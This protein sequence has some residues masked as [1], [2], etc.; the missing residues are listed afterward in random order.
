MN[1][2]ANSNETARPAMSL[3][4]ER[5]CN[6]VFTLDSF[7]AAWGA[8]GLY[9]G[10]SYTTTW[11]DVIHAAGLGCGWCRIIQENGEK[12]RCEVLCNVTMSFSEKNSSGCTPKGVA[13]MRLIINKLHIC[14][15]FIYTEAGKSFDYCN[16]VH[17]ANDRY[18]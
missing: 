18:R 15:F 2:Q 17:A 1:K 13:Y 14:S 10:F 4:C 6:E 3:I 5:C 12:S 11:S 8:T 7:R 9:D 16:H